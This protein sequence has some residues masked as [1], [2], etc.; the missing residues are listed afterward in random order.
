M[1]ANQNSPI[2][3]AK[4]NSATIFRCLPCGSR[5]RSAGILGEPSEIIE[6]EFNGKA[7]FS[8]NVAVDDVH[9]IQIGFR[10]LPV[11]T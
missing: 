2:V 4:D 6:Y 9:V 3:R 7:E 1:N 5:K 8:T 11:V 10:L